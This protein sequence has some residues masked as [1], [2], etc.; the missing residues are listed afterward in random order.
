V[1]TGTVRKIIVQ[2][3]AVQAL[4]LN[5][6]EVLTGGDP[7]DIIKILQLVANKKSPGVYYLKPEAFKEVQLSWPE[8]STTEKEKAREN[9]KQSFDSLKMQTE[10][11]ECLLSETSTLST[12]NSANGSVSGLF[13]PKIETNEIIEDTIDKVNNSQTVVLKD[14]KPPKLLRQIEDN[15]THNN[16]NNII[17][18]ENG[19]IFPQTCAP[20]INRQQYNEYKAEYAKKYDIYKRLDSELNDFKER[21]E[22]LE[23]NFTNCTNSELKENIKREMADLFYAQHRE[24]AKK[25][26]TY[27][28]LHEELK[29]IKEAVRAYAEKMQV[30]GNDEP[31]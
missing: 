10:E 1:D 13:K 24:M 26:E 9:M 12:K 2:R 23:A 4:P 5:K 28:K 29:S 31:S 19:T 22:K 27:K 16:E 6:I 14:V 18:H 30:N 15:H 8:Y 17:K 20:I 7:K 11:Q 3:L 25:S 21:F